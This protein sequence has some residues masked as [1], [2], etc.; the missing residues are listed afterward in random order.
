MAV[1]PSQRS[2]LRSLRLLLLTF[3]G[4][5]LP[6]SA[7]ELG[8]GAANTCRSMGP[9]A[10]LGVCA[11]ILIGTFTGLVTLR[12]RLGKEGWSLANALSEPT[13]LTI[14]I[15]PH[16]SQSQGDDQADQGGTAGI[17]AVVVGS[18]KEGPP[19]AL[20]ILEASSS[21]LIAMVGMVVI[22]LTY[23]GFGI[24]S[25]YTFGLTCQMPASTTAVTSFLYAGLTLFAPYAANKVSGILKPV[26]SS[27]P[28]P[29]PETAGTRLTPQAGG[30]LGPLTAM[31]NPLGA[32]SPA[33][34][35]PGDGD[36]VATAQ[37][38]AAPVA[39]A[40]GPGVPRPVQRNGN[41]S[42]SGTGT[43]A[44]VAASPPRKP[45]GTPPTHRTFP[46]ADP[47]VNGP[48][49]ANHTT[50]TSGAGDPYAA[51]VVLIAQF[52]GFV[53]H[54]YPD[55]ASGGEP[56][57]IGYGFTSI[58]GR[59]VQ[60]GDTISEAEA[61]QQLASGVE[62]CGKHLAGTIPNWA[63][64]A[65]DQRCALISFAWNLGEDFYGSDGFNTISERLRDH[66]WADVPAALELYCDPGSSVSAGLLRR[67][68]GEGDLWR[69]GLGS[70]SVAS[71]ARPAR[72]TS[73][74]H[75]NP[76]N[77][78]WYDQLAMNDGQGWRDCFSASSAMLATYWGKEPNED[79]YNSLRQ[80]YGDTTSA[81][82]QLAALRHLGLQ[83]EF[84]TDGTLQTLWD[85]IDAGRPVAVG[86]LHHGPPSDPGGGGHWTVVIGYDASGVIMNDPYGSCD[87]VNGGYPQNHDGAR[88]HYSYRN[89]EPRWRPQG[90]GGW[91]LTCRP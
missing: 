80:C 77:V 6:A 49:A 37:T 66:A 73:G 4:L 90:S 45:S 35:S 59:P 70:S 38:A 2:W 60:P 69:Q 28:L 22:L 43:A 14:P 72:P 78:R 55:P 5:A 30:R 16:W 32:A 20:T 63:A 39:T 52:E 13:R 48:P 83:A 86:W 46:V 40:V 81:E 9:Q 25:L 50:P 33:A 47:P 12:R 91:Y 74:A 54:A 36:G 23:L 11:I 79:D 62:A 76:L 8:Q 64:M 57:T 82:A 61:K 84:R 27:K 44:G 87:L 7:Q 29:P 15:D 21:R 85:E 89:W 31:T 58:Q 42:A 24:F 88:Q 68:Q 56:W 67:R 65:A 51:A 17:S 41:G 1:L 19:A 71:A 34:A 75:P 53:D 18:A 3:G 10:V 26:L